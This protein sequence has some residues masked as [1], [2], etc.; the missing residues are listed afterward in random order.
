MPRI[1]VRWAT[2]GLALAVMIGA[3][4]ATAAPTKSTGKTKI[5]ATINL[6]AAGVNDF[7]GVDIPY[8]ADLLQK[9]GID[10][11]LTF[12]PDASSALRTLIAGQADLFIGSLPTAIL[13]V[14]NG[15]GKIK[16]LAANNQ[17]SDYVLIGQPGLNQ[18]N[19]SGKTLA[20][21]RPGSAGHVA[22][23]IG[24]EKLGVNPDILRTVRVGNSSARLTAVLAG[25]VDLAPL[26]YP[27]ALTALATGKVINVVNV[28]KAIGPYLQSGLIST[29]SLIAKD[30][31]TVQKVVNAFINAQRWAA[32]NKYNY[33]KYAK[34]NK[35]TANL[36]D[37]QMYK[38]W[39]FYKEISFFG[40]NGG[41]CPANFTAFVKANWRTATLP[42]PLPARS[43]FLNAS[44]VNTYLKAHKQKPN[45]C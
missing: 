35:L 38:V 20:I 29:D 26:H 25:Q 41:I 45:T 5:T 31:A 42:K 23:L 18:N 33:V 37:A 4:G 10:V 9:N 24:L 7:A 28:G 27:D 11:K 30:R 8:F 17:A 36:D 12:V 19:L 13:A 1:L 3:A 32:S 6:T 16:I 40:T 15:G 44:F 34:A 43:D 21:D 22:A 14:T 2:V 39:D